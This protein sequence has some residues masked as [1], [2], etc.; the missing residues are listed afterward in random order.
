MPT[1]N[2]ALVFLLEGV[3]RACLVIIGQHQ[4]EQ[5][6]D[7]LIER[8]S[9][10]GKRKSV[11]KTR[12]FASIWHYFIKLIH[13]LRLVSPMCCFCASREQARK[14]FAPPLLLTPAPNEQQWGAFRKQLFWGYKSGFQGSD[15]IIMCVCVKC[16]SCA[17]LL[18]TSTMLMQ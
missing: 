13:L 5:L 9:W 18:Y 16:S 2:S 12:D 1:L 11:K 6:S 8:P 4:E 15:V 7:S 10:P 3:L 14:K 17:L